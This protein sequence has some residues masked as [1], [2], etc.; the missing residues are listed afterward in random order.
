[1]IRILD[2]GCGVGPE[3]SATD[4]NAVFSDVTDKEIVRL[5][6]NPDAHP[7]FIHDITQPLPEELRSAFDIVLC[8]HVMEHIRRPQVLD[9]FRNTI[10][11]VKNMGEVWFIVP[12]MEFA[13]GEILKHRD[14]ASVQA[15]I[16]GGQAS[17]LDTHYCGYTLQALRFM[18]ELCGLV[19]RKAYQAPFSIE[20]DG[21]SHTCIQNIVV[22]ARYDGLNDPASAVS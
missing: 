9:A 22:G 11:G 6:A 15:L 19:V 5:D 17:D 20:V 1:M 4:P 16:F 13:A 14:G 3:S 12:S 8:S 21:K 2:V 7:D 18:V 10:S